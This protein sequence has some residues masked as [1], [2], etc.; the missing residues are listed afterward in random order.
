MLPPAPDSPRRPGTP[1]AGR[2]RHAGPG[3]AETRGGSSRSPQPGGLP[4]STGSTGSA[5]PAA[6]GI[7]GSATAKWA[8]GVL[9]PVG[10]RG[11]P[12]PW[13][14]SGHKKGEERKD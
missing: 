8:R 6:T 4:G 7:P 10:V 12:L 3:D 5:G 2:T 11:D 1:T 9:L 14:G 13:D